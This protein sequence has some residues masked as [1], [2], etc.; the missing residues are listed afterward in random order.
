MGIAYKLVQEEEAES[1]PPCQSFS[2]SM[3]K[4]DG[5]TLSVWMLGGHPQLQGSIQMSVG[6]W[7]ENH[8]LMFIF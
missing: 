5:E 3:R 1:C 4:T 7:M 8:G 6:N 2:E